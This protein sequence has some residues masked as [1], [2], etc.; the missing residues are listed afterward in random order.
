V[1]GIKDESKTDDL[2]VMNDYGQP[3]LYP[4]ELFL[5]VDNRYPSDW[6][7]E[8]GEEGE[9]YS[10]PKVFQQPGFFEDYFDGEQYAV[11]VFYRYLIFGTMNKSLFIN[12]FL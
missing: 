10:Y 6:E 5:V 4:Q 11:N 8:Y 1:A 3:Y 2:R 12:P 9:R 7:T